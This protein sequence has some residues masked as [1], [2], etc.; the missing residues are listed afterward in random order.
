VE[1][2]LYEEVALTVN[3]VK[4]YTTNCRMLV[5]D[6]TTLT[7]IDDTKEEIEADPGDT[8]VIV[9]PETDTTFV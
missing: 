6:D 5:A 9:D 8:P 4:A 3:P 2:S 7:G 1:V